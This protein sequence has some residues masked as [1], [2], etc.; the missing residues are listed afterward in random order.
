[1]ATNPI[2]GE[3][4]MKILTDK[5]SS[6]NLRTYFNI[7]RSDSP[8]LYTGARF[9]TLDGGGSREEV[10]DKIT[11]WDL[12]AVECLGV[13]V[14]APVALDLIDGQL[15]EQISDHLRKV[16]TNV[17]LGEDGAKELLV[18]GSPAERAW[19]L[20][21]DQEDVG[22][23]I[24]GKV[25]ARKRPQLIPVWDSVVQC[26]LGVRR[27]AWLWLDELLRSEEVGLKA[28]LD[29]LHRSAELPELVSRIRVLDVVIWMRHSR[30]HRKVR[31]PG[32]ADDR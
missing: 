14:P 12:L 25:M 15:G 10:R 21:K 32:L 17:A 28:R 22:W 23:V 31:C 20:L 27:H 19:H 2:S 24:A 26:G 16:P 1:M 5:A 9:E 11:P 29:T 8:P 18:D 6:E 3:A 4:L 13:R 7:G 30:H